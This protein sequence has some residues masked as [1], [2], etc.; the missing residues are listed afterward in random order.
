MSGLVIVETHPVQYHAPVW[1]HAFVQ[2]KVPLQVV[3][4]GDFS[5]RGYR[6]REFGETFQWETDLL[7]GYPSRVLQPQAG[8]YEGVNATGLVAALDTM[9]PAA[10]LVL[11]YHHPLDRAAL[12]WAMKK[13]VPLLFR[14]ETS[15]LPRSGRSWLRAWLRDL[16]LRRL[17]RQCE[18]C[19]YLGERSREHYRRL[20]VDE[21]DL[22]HSPYCVDTSAFQTDDA[23]RERLRAQTRR[24]AGIPED[25]WVLLF[26]GKL[27]TRKGVD[28]LPQALRSLPKALRSKAFLVCVGSGE[29]REALEAACA[30]EPVLGSHFTGFVNQAGLSAWY[31]AADVL[32]L[33]SLE[34]ETW[35]L[36]VND[37]LHHGVPAVVSDAV[38]CA[39]DLIA[40][41]RT[42]EVCKA[43]SASSLACA[44]ESC[45]S[46]CQED[47]V[48][49]RRRCREL[50]ERYTV[51]NAAAGLCEAWSKVSK[52][53]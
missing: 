30:R 20:G 26:S 6:D 1:R 53:S 29:R 37:A 10:L 17:Y 15:D 12:R 21:D 51:A 4:G 27:S 50:A 52:I 47:P 31:H 9:R 36:V 19:L 35:G 22:I 18:V 42:G 44:L 7:A 13:K 14:G 49:T 48:A 11:G 28:L 33:P 40:S 46:W 45:A 8:D 2:E 5:V 34:M 25:A 38:G 39:P 41:W 43:G 16:M 24:A 32:V 23:A 3:Y